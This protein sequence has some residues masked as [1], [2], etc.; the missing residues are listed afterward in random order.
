MIIIPSKEISK[1]D[2][3]LIVS[4][5][6]I[7]FILLDCLN[8]NSDSFTNVNTIVPLSPTNVTAVAG[9]AQANVTWTV[10]AN[11]G[12]NI[13]S[14]IIK[15]NVNTNTVTVNASTFL[16]TSSTS[17]PTVPATSTTVNGLTG[18]ITATIPGLI[19]GISYT[20]TVQAV[21]TVGSSIVTSASTS[22]SVTPTAPAQTIPSVV[23]NVIAT[24]GNG[25]ASITWNV[26]I[27][28]GGSNISSYTIKNNVNTNTVMVN[29]SNLLTIS[30]TSAAN[31]IA[32]TTTVNGLIATITAT[33]PGLINGISYI[34]TVQAV[35]TV[36][37]SIVTSA[38]TSNSVIPTAPVQTIPSVVTNV[39]ATAGN[40]QAI[41]T[42]NV[43]INNGGSNISSYTI[44]NNVNTNTVMVNTSN[45]LTISSTSAPTS[46]PTSTA[47]TTTVNGLTATITATVPGLINGISYTFTVQAINTVGSSIINSASTSNSVIPNAST[48]TQ[49]T[50]VTATAGN[51]QASVTWTVP[52]NNIGS[53]I[54]SYVIKN[55]VNTNIATFVDASS[56]LTTTRTPTTIISPTSTAT[57]TTVN[58]LTT[59]TA[60][61]LGLIN[62]TPYTFT[63]QTKNGLNLS[64]ITSASTSNSVTPTA[65]QQSYA[66]LLSNVF[67]EINQ[68]NVQNSLEVDN[69]NNCGVEMEKL[70]KVVGNQ[71]SNLQNKIK[72]L[73]SKSND[74]HL[75]KYMNFLITDLLERGILDN[76]D[77][78]NIKGKINNKLLTEDEAIVGLEKLK[79]SGKSKQNKPDTN[80][81]NQPAYSFNNLP[82]EYSFGTL[83]P[84]MYKPL[85][86]SDLNKW[87]EE[88]YTMLN[89]DKWQLP[90]ARPP[91]CINTSPCK[92][93]PDTNN[94]YPVPLAQWDNSRKVSNIEI[95]KEWANTLVDPKENLV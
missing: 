6:S 87:D 48:Q 67:D 61:V 34:F 76:N 47:T 45:L 18:T 41:V 88:G 84:E 11:N 9:N 71:M 33:V 36:G 93:C 50:N 2:L 86:N 7:S 77:I 4:V 8:N 82:Q 27:N 26:P 66:T 79:L 62:G 3:I 22:N 21:N 43:P 74:G 37:S 1:M 10:P 68:S 25:Q 44:R 23:T 30:S 54:S 14:Y 15:N 65:P 58:G 55:N 31:S 19:N 56:F 28:N 38:S 51:A 49:L 52:S 64:S 59:I 89:T 80:E 90:M 81:N 72:E 42:W 75:M 91:V 5:I 78:E 46:A 20:F 12:A 24:A 40:G 94:T 70:K 39:I 57:T 63:V 53:N 16:T 85:G 92:V 32:T 73:E 95:S 35:N 83:P 17:V 29:T 69:T 60:T 13:S